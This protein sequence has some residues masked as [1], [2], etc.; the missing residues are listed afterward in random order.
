MVGTDVTTVL[1]IERAS[2]TA[3]HWSEAQYSVCLGNS[4][5]S[6]L[7][8][9]GLVAELDG[10]VAGFGVVRILVT[11]ASA[12]AELESIVV[13]AKW[14]G[15]GIGS[16]LMGRLLKS[17]RAEGVQRLDLEVRAS[18]TAAIGLYGRSGLE[19]TGRRRGYYRDP[20]EDAIR[21]AV[22]L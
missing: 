12:E 5:D 22:R 17:A 15:R 16:V 1:A 2:E 6:A 4:G 21:M 3:P 14:R 9:V 11:P 19:E 18:N 10:E 7:R 20:E 13:A 8:R